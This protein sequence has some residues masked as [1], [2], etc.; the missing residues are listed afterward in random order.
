MATRT[1]PSPPSTVLIVGA[2][3]FGAAT[4]LS[5][6]KGPYAG[7]EHLITILDRSSDPPAIDAASSDY[8][9]I[10]RQDYSDA[11]YAALACAA[12]SLWR[13]DEYRAHFHECGITVT[14]SRTDPQAKYVRESLAVNQLPE[15]LCTG[16]RA[17][18]LPDAVAAKAQY[19]GV[20][21]GD[22]EGNAAYKNEAGGWADSRGGVVDVL[23]RVRNLGVKFAAGEAS[24]LIF[25]EISGG[26]NVK[27]VKTKQGDTLIGD[28]VVLCTGAW[29]S[30]LLPELGHDLLPTGQAVGTIQLSPQEAEVYASVPVGFFLDSGFYCFPPN[31]EGIVKFAIHDRGWLDPQLGLPS[32]PRTTLTVGYE[33]QQVPPAASR[34]LRDGLRRLYPRLAEKEFLET[35]LCWYTDRPSGDWLLDYHPSY[36]SLFVA[37]GG[38]GHAFIANVHTRPRFCP[39][40]QRAWVAL[41]EKGIPYQYKEVNPYH[42]TKDFLTINPKGLVPAFEHQGTAL[43]ESTV[44]LEIDYISKKVVPGFFKLIQ[45][46]DVPA[47]DDARAELTSS[48]KELSGNVHGPFYAGEQFGAVDI[49]LAPFLMRLYI[50]EKH[51]NFKAED[52]GQKFVDWAKACTTRPSMVSTSSDMV[53]YEEIYARYLKNEAQRVEAE[54]KHDKSE[55]NA[56]QTHG[57]AAWGAVFTISTVGSILR[58][59]RNTNSFCAGGGWLSN[60]TLVSVGG[61]PREGTYETAAAGQGLGAIRL[62]TPCN[63][64]SCDVYENPQRIHMTGKRWYASTTRLTDGSIMILGA[65]PLSLNVFRFKADARLMDSGGMV[66][67]GYNNAPATDNPTSVSLQPR[68]TIRPDQLFSDRFEFYPPKFDGM[69]I[70]SKFLHDALDTNLF[71]VTYL[72]PDGTIFVAANTMAMIYNW[73]KNTERRLPTIPNG[74]QISYPATAASALLPLTVANNWTPEILFCGGSTANTQINPVYLSSQTPASNQC[75]RMVLTAAGIKKPWSVEQMPEQRVMGD[76]VLTP[77]G[78]VFLV[79]GGKSGIAGYGNVADEVG[80]SNAANP[81]FRPTL[82]DPQ[83]TAGQR[84]TTNFPSS[85]IERLYHSSA[86]LIP[87][88]RIFISGS[89]PNDDVSKTTYATRYQNEMFSPPYFFATRPTFSGIPTNILYGKTFSLKI[90]VPSSAKVVQAVIMDLGYSTHAVHMNNRHVELVVTRSGKTAVTIT[91]PANTGIYPPGY[92]WLFIL[93]DTVPSKGLRVMIGPGNGEWLYFDSSGLYYLPNLPFFTLSGPPVS[94]SAIDNLNAK[95]APIITRE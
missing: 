88:G 44:L 55:G 1:P 85:N 47:Q 78:K 41:E 82:Y 53:H 38:S 83:G 34:A 90:A 30:T 33:N 72:L 39:F 59:V 31:K 91:G 89:N 51:R 46:Q 15:M 76:A 25:E 67:G 7:H 52:A 79:N 19:P 23:A 58:P 42:K 65:S 35:R 80:N 9:K 61:N 70:Y 10:I 93:A 6:V 49:C 13:S 95:V 36:K 28:L 16:K 18:E 3:E 94:Q 87:D 2:G 22:L 43:Y 12:M 8:N 60:G 24:E 14:S 32:I 54:Q 50:L 62:F 63:G 29:T 69:A 57:H 45:A 75:V 71:P 92:A 48:L 73:K 4:A 11:F 77:D 40:N 81:D 37:S 68:G 64:G 5:L 86:T 84:F 56:L 17:F 21:T 27:G 74:V 66:A 20:E 26:Q